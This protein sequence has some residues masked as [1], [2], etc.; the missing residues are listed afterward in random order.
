MVIPGDCFVTQDGQSHIL[1]ADL[2]SPL[3]G[4]GSAPMRRVGKSRAGRLLDGREH[5]DFP[6][7]LIPAQAG[8]Q[9]PTS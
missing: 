8:I 1:G 7:P 3:E 9:E 6:E 2:S 5:N 4:N